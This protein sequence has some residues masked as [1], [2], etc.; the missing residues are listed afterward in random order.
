LAS[1]LA[2][3]ASAATFTLPTDDSTVVGNVIVVKPTPTNTLLDIARH[4]DLGYEEIVTANPDVSV[5]KPGRRVVVP[6]QFI[7]PPKPWQGIVVNIPQRRLYYFPAEG[8]GQQPKRVITYPISI[9][10]EGW[11]TPLGTTRLTAKYKDPSWLV[12][13]SIQ[14]EHLRE[15]GVELPEYF[16]P[17]PDNP[18]GM[19]AMRTGFPGIFIHATNRPWGVGMRTSHG[20]LH[21]YPEDAAEMFPLVKVG[22][23]VR[24][25]NEPLL[26]GNDHGRWVMAS[27]E[28][29]A[30]YQ[31]EPPLEARAEQVLITLSQTAVDQERIQQLIDTP[32]AIPVALSADEPDLTEWLTTLPIVAYNYQPYGMD[33]NNAQLPERPALQ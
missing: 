29:V 7:L 18:M 12:P 1:T 3:F 30:E 25:I 2:S 32:Q 10:R 23:P 14:E 8:K 24:V 31:N 21:L 17:G 22:T 33:A 9:A 15:E 28:P 26:V 5:W 16:P 11:S 20:C 19:L 13:K 27:F 6:R 4:Y